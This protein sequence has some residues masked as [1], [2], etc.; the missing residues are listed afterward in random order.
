MRFCGL[1]KK[2]VKPECGRETEGWVESF[3]SLGDD[4][5]YSKMFDTVASDEFVAQVILNALPELKA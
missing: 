1:A 4:K 2:D 3:W 5:Y